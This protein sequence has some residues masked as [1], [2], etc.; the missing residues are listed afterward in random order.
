M[1]IVLP[2]KLSRYFTLQELTR[3][4]AAPR[5]GIDNSCP[6]GLIPR[7]KKTA[8]QLDKIRELTGCPIYVVSGFRRPELN[9]AIGGAAT[10]QH[11]KAEAAD[12]VCPEYGRVSELATLIFENI[13]ELEVDQL[14]VE[15]YQWCHVS[16]TEGTPRWQVLTMR[17]RKE[18][19]LKG[20]KF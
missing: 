7:L 15:F 9:S 5:L 13:K 10:S 19:Y 3:S 18:G 17:S 14:I 16:F 12:I 2:M 6:A 20:L 11:L 8:F 1:G 4:E